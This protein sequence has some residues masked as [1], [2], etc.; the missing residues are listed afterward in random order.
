MDDRSPNYEVRLDRLEADVRRIAELADQSA[1]RE[2]RLGQVRNPR[3]AK[4]VMGDVSY[5]A[6]D[7]SPVPNTYPIVFLDSTWTEDQGGQT[8]THTERQTN[9]AALAH[10]PDEKPYAYLPEGSIV[11][12]AWDNR[13]W[14]IVASFTRQASWIQ[15]TVNDAEGLG[16]SD[17]SVTVD[18]VT[19]HHGHQP[20]DEVTTV[21]NTGWGGEDDQEGVAL[22]DADDGKYYIAA[23]APGA[24]EDVLTD[25]QVDAENQ[26]L[27]IKTRQMLIWPLADETEWTDKHTGSVCP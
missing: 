19:Y 12:V 25:F 4:T 10:L 23:M 14:W 2:A 21:Y 20:A 15:F 1:E 26:K 24:T 13:R 27:Q 11:V 3:L 22:H 18:G 17:E 5:P 9:Y 16:T 7:D 6:A 8:P